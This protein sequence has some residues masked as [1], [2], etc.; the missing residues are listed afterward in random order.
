MAVNLRN[1]SFCKELDFSPDQLRF[2]IGLGA[3]LKRANSAGTERPRL[4]GKRIAL[5]F[6]KASTRTRVAFEVAA[7][8]HGAH[9]TYLG[10]TGT[11]I[12]HE[13]SIKDTARV[14]GRIYDGIAY[15]GFGQ[16]VVETLAA[17][18]GVPVWNGLTDQWH[19]TQMLADM[20]TMSEHSP[21][22]LHQ[23]AYCYLGDAR[24]NTG[25]SLLVTGAMLGMDVRIAAPGALWPADELIAKAR[26]IAAD[27]G[28]RVSVT[29]DVDDAVAGVDYLYTDVWLSMGEPAD[30]WDAR[31]RLLRPYQVN[32]EVVKKTG[33]PQVKFLHCLP[34]LHNRDTAVGEQ[35]YQR[36]GLSGLEVTDE[37]F[38]SGS[39]L[40][41]AQAENRLHTIKAV[42]VATLG[43]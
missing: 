4:P 23:I 10:P 42:M 38:E 34:S 27:T 20:L 8:D 17:D 36:T 7:Y 41:F 28:A 22:P 39:S 21:K 25:H 9:V 12:G 11:H 3:D 35:L 33:N 1:R 5:V 6:E 29:D 13:E 31:I 18:A 26:Q 37:V 24:N 43:D 40:V 32:G 14:L 15:R 16:D 19:P 2:L 30:K